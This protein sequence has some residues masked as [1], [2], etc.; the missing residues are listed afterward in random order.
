MASEFKLKLYGLIVGMTNF[1]TE[2]TIIGKS[3]NF[4]RR[5]FWKYLVGLFIFHIISIRYNFFM[6]FFDMA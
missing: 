5:P 1:V 6:S 3:A 2:P 4:D